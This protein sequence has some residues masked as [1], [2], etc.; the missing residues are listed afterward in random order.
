MD[1]T[2]HIN[3]KDPKET[4]RA[5]RNIYDNLF[6]SSSFEKVEYT[7]GDVIRLFDGEYPGYQG[8]DTPYHDLEHTLQAYL[9]TARMFDGLMQENPASMQEEDLILGLVSALWHD[10]GFIKETSD[11]EGSGAKYT[12]VHV[13]RSR[14]FVGKYL[15]E[16][17]LNLTEIC[18]VKN[19]I[20]CTGLWPTLS[21]IPFN[22]ESER[23]AGYIVGTAD[24]LGQM[25]DP[26][27]LQKL[28]LL[29]DE[30][31]ESGIYDYSCAQELMEKTPI[32]FQ[33]FVMKRLKVDFQSVYRFVGNHFNGRN[34]YIEGINKN[35]NQLESILLNEINPRVS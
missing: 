11:T 8:C 20:S 16:L 27:Y 6:G 9:A 3:T 34:L 35:I 14:K 17:G 5:V 24:Y 7:L 4:N 19:N 13:N 10:T 15:P 23:I 21:R 18:F 30:F 26:G 12:L 22:S 28:H 2:G 32:F 33:D 29:Y 31:I 1:V 25:S